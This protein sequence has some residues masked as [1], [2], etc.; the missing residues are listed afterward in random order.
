MPG[1]APDTS[2]IPV[3]QE[4]GKGRKANEKEEE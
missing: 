4:D 3:L 2:F 1:T